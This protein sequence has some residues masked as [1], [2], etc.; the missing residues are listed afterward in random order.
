MTD[1]IDGVSEAIDRYEP[2]RLIMLDANAIE[3]QKVRWLWPGRIALRKITLLA[4]DPGLGKSL[5]TID[6]VARVTRGKPWPLENAAASE[7]SA[8][9]LSAEDDPA[10]TMVPRLM[11]A[12]ADLMRVKLLDCVRETSVSG[13][14]FDRGFSL[15]RDVQLLER[16]LALMPD[17]RLIVVDPISAYLGGTDTHRNADVRAL[18]TPLIKLAQ[19]HDVAIV[20]VSHLNKGTGLHANYRITGSIAFTATARAVYLIAKDPYDPKRRLMMPIKNNLAEDE[21]GLAYGINVTPAEGRV[22]L[23]A[24]QHPASRRGCRNR[25]WRRLDL[26]PQRN[27]SLADVK[28]SNSIN[29]VGS[30][31]P[32]TPW[33]SA[34]LKCRESA[35]TGRTPVAV[36]VM[37]FS[38]AVSGLTEP[39]HQLGSRGRDNVYPSEEASREPMAAER[40]SKCAQPRQQIHATRSH[41]NCV[42]KAQEY[43]TRGSWRATARRDQRDAPKVPS[44]LRGVAV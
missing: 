20:A 40:T 34:Q 2:A 6:L 15:E 13:N 18:L 19:R 43:Q 30:V 26:V 22:F 11:A 39:T 41:W 37:K 33:T 44:S 17:C 10:D 14:P 4:S 32:S 38:T 35:P 27:H 36:G 5:V 16:E 25:L 3:P 1:S 8:L 9:I 29:A 31:S 42:L 23:I 28:N 12:D 24:L 7:G 21:A